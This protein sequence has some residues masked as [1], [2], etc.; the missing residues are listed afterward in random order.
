MG[1]PRIK[2]IVCVSLRYYFSLERC[3]SWQQV[4]YIANICYTLIVHTDGVCV[5]HAFSWKRKQK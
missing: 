1:K 2:E 5:R 4:V 3:T